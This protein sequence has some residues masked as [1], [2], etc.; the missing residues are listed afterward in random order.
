M[1]STTTTVSRNARSRSGKRG[2][3][4]ASSPS[5]KAVSVDIATPQPRA[6][7]LAGVEGQVDRDR[8]PSRRRR[9]AAAARAGA[10]RA[11]RRGR[12]RA[13]PRARR[14]RRRVIS[15]LLTQS[16]RS[17]ATP[18]SPRSIESVVVQTLVGVRVDVHPHERGDRGGEQ[19]GGTAGLGAEEL[20]QRRL[21]V[22][23]PRGA[24]TEARIAR[25]GRRLG[26]RRVGH[27]QATPAAVGVACAD[28]RGII[29]LASHAWCG[30]NARL[31]ETQ[32]RGAED[33]ALRRATP[34]G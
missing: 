21:E 12:T 30:A 7:G 8:P 14:R 33:A 11:A 28:I 13:A 17:S 25:V 27:D 3:T 26:V 23:R 20:P 15:P 34:Q 31:A 4:S 19:H 2:P 18:P 16:R 22:A 24:P 10:A 6:D 9:R 1:S 5:A 29:V 32:E